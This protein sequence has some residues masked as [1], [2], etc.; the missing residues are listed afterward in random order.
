MKVLHTPQNWQESQ[1]QIPL[2][3]RVREL[4]QPNNARVSSGAGEVGKRWLYEELS[5]Q[6]F[7]RSTHGGH[8]YS[9]PSAHSKK[10]QTENEVVGENTAA[11]MEQKS[12]EEVNLQLGAMGA[13][14]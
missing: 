8:T 11:L 13:V 10:Q 6:L 14:P 5:F 12:T 2:C 4:P 7:P 9:S 3:S 1:R